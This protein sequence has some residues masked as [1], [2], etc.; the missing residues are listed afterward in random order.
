MLAARSKQNHFA[1]FEQ[2]DARAEHESFGDIVGDENHGLC[3]V[4]AGAILNSRWISRRVIGSSAPNGSSSKITGG[5]AASARATPTRW[6]WPAGKLARESRRET[7]GVESDQRQQR[8]RPLLDSFC[9][10]ILQTRH[11]ADIFF[12]RQMREQTDLLNHVTDAPAQPDRIPIHR[13]LCPRLAP[14]RRSG[15]CSRLINF[16]VVVLPEP[17]RPSSTNV[18]PAFTLRLRVRQQ[19]LAV[20]QGKADVAKFDGSLGSMASNISCSLGRIR[21]HFLL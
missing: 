9:R 3:Q 21:R 14:R 12:H 8:A 17:L 1:V 6:R 4:L 19:R 20:R 11:D 16:I 5:S 2:S 13:P 15:R 10:P 18:S 7:I